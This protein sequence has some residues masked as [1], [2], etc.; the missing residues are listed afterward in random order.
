M[1]LEGTSISMSTD[2]LQ[3]HRQ[4]CNAAQH[5]TLAFAPLLQNKTGQAQAS[6]GSAHG[7]VQAWRRAPVGT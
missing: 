6:S 1:L 5:M 2:G 4:P 3:P 7:P